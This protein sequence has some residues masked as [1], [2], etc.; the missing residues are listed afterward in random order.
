MTEE[1]RA[2]DCKF[3]RLA[4]GSF[5][6]KRSRRETRSEYS[7]EDEGTSSKGCKIGQERQNLAQALLGA[8]FRL[9]GCSSLR[10][11]VVLWALAWF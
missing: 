3:V 1:V 8:C 10:C 4:D 9:C 5:A 2:A 6:S 7:D 11:F